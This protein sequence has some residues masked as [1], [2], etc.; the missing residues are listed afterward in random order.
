MPPTEKS[1]KNSEQKWDF[2]PEPLILHTK[3]DRRVREGWRRGRSLMG[4]LS[5]GELDRRLIVDD[6]GRKL[7]GLWEIERG[8]M[9]MKLNEW[10][11]F[12]V[13]SWNWNCAILYCKDR[14]KRDSSPLVW[15]CL[16]MFVHQIQ[17]ANFPQWR[18]VD[19]GPVS[20]EA[21]PR[22]IKLCGLGLWCQFTLAWKAQSD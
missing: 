2:L 8:A 11:G 21:G 4:K 1:H 18:V 6:F 9:G 7:K 5:F 10:C 12:T 15:R 19:M 3:R 17:S 22:E 13:A 16:L 20:E 14:A